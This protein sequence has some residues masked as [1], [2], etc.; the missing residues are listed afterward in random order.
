M[1][2]R[3]G[4]QF[5]TSKALL[6]GIA[7]IAVM[8]APG[9][10]AATCTWNS[11]DGAWLA[12]GN[13]L[14]CADGPGPSTR[15]PGPDDIAVIVNGIAN[16][17]S[18]PTVAEL[19]LGAG[20]RIHAPGSTRVLTVTESLRLNGG[21]SSGV[22]GVTQL[23]LVLA[24]GASGSLLASSS[25]E[26]ATFL[27][28]SGNLALG[29]A[30]GTSLSLKNYAELQNF[31]GGTITLVGGDSRLYLEEGASVINQ[32]GASIAISGN[33]QIGKPTPA[34]SIHH[35]KNFGS[36][37]MS[38]PGTLS[39]PGGGGGLVEFWQFGQ[40]TIT[41]ATVRCNLVAVA[42]RWSDI[43]GGGSSAAF[44]RM[45]NGQIDAGGPAANFGVS[46]GATLTGT[47]SINA[48]LSTANG[49][50]APGAL[51]GLPYGT[52]AFSG[53]GA[54]NS[55]QLDLD[56]GGA[57]AGNHDAISFGGNLSV[58]NSSSADGNG[59]LSLRLAPGYAPTLGSAV[60]VLSYA[61]V[62]PDAGFNLVEANYALDYATRFDATELNVFPAPRLIME[63][64]SLTEGAN[65]SAVMTFNLR[66]SQP[67]NV[68]VTITELRE[69]AGSAS[70]GLPPDGDYTAG[71]QAFTFAPGEVLKHAVAT[72]YGD[73]VVEGDEAFMLQLRRNG[74]LLNA[75]HGN[76]LRGRQN[77]IGTILSDELAPGTRMLLVGTDSTTHHIRRFTTDGAFIDNWLTDAQPFTYNGYSG[78]CFAPDGSILSTRFF[79]NTQG[80]ALFS[81]QGAL[82][83]E[84]FA[85]GT[86][87]NSHESCVYDRAGNV[88][89][90]QAGFN[91]SVPDAQIPLLKF[92][93]SG[94]LLDSFVLP[95]GERGV[96]WIELAGDQCTLYY[97]SEDTTVRRYNVCTRSA[98]PSLTASLSGTYCYALRLRANRE[99]M[100]ACTAGVH[101]LD[102]DG[103]EL[104]F[105]SRESL[106]ETDVNGLF[107]INLDPDGTSFW[108]A[109]A[110]SGKVY[111]VDIASGTVLTTI[112]DIGGAI[113]GL[114][115]YDEPGDDTIF[116]DDFELPPVPPAP[117]AARPCVD[118]LIEPG[119]NLPQFIPHWLDALLV[120][121]G[122]DCAD[123]HTADQ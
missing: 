64:A 75:A 119:D 39:F 35:V 77:V 8:C 26:T 71:T 24:A 112:T 113:S 6:P 106:G 115:I 104:Q 67:S 49:L 32:V 117:T 120:S 62:S 65:G 59:R 27:M 70:N 96:D 16:L 74:K 41:N 43:N 89:I 76:G 102:E 103:D 92:S 114:A 116:A 40:F 110:T 33:T 12:S 15:S 20:G 101:R 4:K 1:S 37:S 93:A 58:G 81:R 94:V 45:V 44:T 87:F 90:G 118:L 88:Y 122:D 7:L 25:L 14:N 84:S 19:E 53:T 56:I 97:T 79:A 23:H 107:A 123:L 10:Q 47:G 60:P 100:V 69:R 105:Y 121:D 54:I 5:R 83:A 31:S 73:N 29:S 108:T 17:G 82:L 85:A 99:L 22:L 51:S 11:A 86:V 95:T 2:Q 109:G 66:L 30:S 46:K 63:H 78:F 68:P 21:A 28:N 52:L 13:W 98:L 42:C 34:N 9:V 50:L 72:I 57:T 80:P 3:I 48:R 18:S 61:S 38:G 111:R 91:S 55:G 36:M